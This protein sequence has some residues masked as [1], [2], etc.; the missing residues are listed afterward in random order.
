MNIK[1]SAQ[2]WKQYKKVFGA[3]QDNT[4]CNLKKED[5]LVT[6]D[7]EKEKLLFDTFFTGKHLNKQVPD[8]THDDAVKKNYEEIRNSFKSGEEKKPKSF[9]DEEIILEEIREAIKKQDTVEKASDFDKTHPCLLKKLGDTALQTLCTIFNWSLNHGKWL[10]DTSYV[11]FI[12]KEDKS[13]YMYPGSYR[14]ITVASYFGKIL[15]RILDTRIRKK[16]GIEEILD[17]DQEGFM[18]GRCTTRY[19]FRLLANLEEVKRQR[20]ACIIL[21]IDFEKAFDSVFLPSLIV[22]LSGYGVSGKILK[23]LHSFL[24]ERK[25][26]LK[27]NKHLGQP[28]YCTVFG[29][30]QG[31]ALSPLLFILYI[32]DMTDNIPESVKNYLSCYKYADDGTLMMTHETMKTCHEKMQ[33]VCDNLTKWCTMNKLVINCD[34]NKTEAMVLKTNY[35][36]T[37]DIPPELNI[38]NQKIRY[39]THTRVLGILIDD[40]LKFDQ[41]A[42][43]KLKDCKKK[44]GL[45]TKSTNRNHGLNI[46][47]LT[48]LLKTTVLTKLLYAAPLWLGKNMDIFT[49]FWNK[50][51][52][53]ISGAMLNPQRDLTELALHLPPLNVQLEV[54]TVKFLCKVLTCNDHI[55]SVLHQIDGTSKSGLHNQISM[56][57]RFLLWKGNKSRGI[58]VFDL[59][60][61]E[62]GEAAHYSKEEMKR[63]QQ[64]VW[65][66]YVKN[67]TAVKG[68]GSETEEK[69]SQVV[70]KM[71]NSQV[72]LNKDNFIFNYGTTKAEDSFIMDF[73]HGNSL[74]FGKT[75]STLSKDANENFCPFCN[76]RDDN[77]A[78][79][80]LE[81]NEVKDDT[82]NDLQMV[83]EQPSSHYLEEVLTPTKPTKTETRNVQQRFINRIVFL[84]GQHDTYWNEDE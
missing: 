49:S 78:H 60:N 26:C 2:F 9:L 58:K 72:V 44:W 46:R 34:I 29:L 40:E 74:F 52:M 1:D 14:P 71:K 30:P 37:Q 83:L 54:L 36:D 33:S 48:L 39:V 3:T 55:T 38:S 80:L 53:K 32:T 70:E 76:Q 47:S 15:E 10:W 77:P 43:Q 82:H 8:K 20:L 64:T 16:I 45:I 31:S 62:N 4:I 22:K 81:C 21:F 75:R 65:I 28:T 56:L 63:Y 35:E 59:L 11:S 18:S 13:S 51:I 23:L 6:S 5:I 25:V 24:F 7:K 67:K 66:D 17:D 73:I 69:L 68:S 12:R 50:I 57:K 41:H 19:L 84:K 27:V 61:P 42:N 79:Q